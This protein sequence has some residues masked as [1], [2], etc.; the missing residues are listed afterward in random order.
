MTFIDKWLETV[1]KK[2]SVLCAG[3]DPAEYDMGRD[4]KGLPEGTDKFEW[5]LAY[6]EAVAPYCAAIKPNLQYWK[7]VS[8]MYV[9]TEISKVAHENGM[10][11]IDDSK[12]SDIGSTNEAGVYYAAK[13]GADAVTYAPFAMNIKEV[14]EQ[15]DKWDVGIISLCIMS[16]P[17]YAAMKNAMI[18]L[19]DG[20]RRRM[21][22][23]IAMQC[24]EYGIDGVVIGAPSETNHITSDEIWT[25]R[26]HLDDQLVL[27]PGVGAQGGEADAIWNYF[28]KDC[29]IVNVGR[30]F[31]FP[32]NDSSWAEKGEEYRDMLNGLRKKA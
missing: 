28:G 6:I 16:N 31:M 4:S 27:L 2:D 18:T 3:L 26:S 13:H 14:A 8:D 10:V 12:L 22:E 1:E 23:A 17:E 5:A 21:F 11:V 32:G 9:L 20:V 30:S 19:E 29:V 15:G 24:G 25:A 7:D